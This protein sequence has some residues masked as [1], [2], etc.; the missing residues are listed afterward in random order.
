MIKTKTHG[1]GGGD[2]MRRAVFVL[3]ALGEPEGRDLSTWLRNWTEGRRSGSSALTVCR[4]GDTNDSSAGGNDAAPPAEVLE[5]FEGAGCE[6]VA[7]S[8]AG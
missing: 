3:L 6:V 7:S 8:V 5:S 4:N 1:G 2:D